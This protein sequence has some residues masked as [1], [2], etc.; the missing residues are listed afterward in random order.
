MIV[1]KIVC[2]FGNQLFCYACGYA[3]AKRKKTR[4]LVDALTYDKAYDREFT[5][6]EIFE[7]ENERN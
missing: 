1:T 3:L 7:T 5:Y 6:K 4:L 2:G